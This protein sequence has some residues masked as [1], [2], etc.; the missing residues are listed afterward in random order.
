MQRF[1]RR[2]GFWKRMINSSITTMMIAVALFNPTASQPVN[3]AA[4]LTVTPITWNVVGLDS[5]NVS[6]GPNIFP[7]GA[8]VCNTGDSPATNVTATFAWLETTNQANIY[9]RAGTASTYTSSSSLNAGSCKDFF[10]EIEVLRAS[11]SYNKTRDYQ[12]SFTAD[13]GLTG[14]TPLPREIYVEKLV[15]QNR[16]SVT[17]IQLDGVSIPAG[18]VMT[19][20]V[21]N[22]YNITLF[23][24]TATAYNQLES[25]ISLSNTI[26]RINSVASTYSTVSYAPPSSD[27]LYADSCGWDNG[28][29]SPTYRSCIVSDGKSGGNVTV[30]YNVTILSGG[31]ANQMLNAMFYD[32]SGSSYH[33]N[34]DFSLSSRVVNVITPVEFSKIFPD[35]S[36]TAG[37]VTPLE[38]T[39]TNR[40]AT[41]IN[42]VTFND[43]LPTIGASQLT[44]A[45]PPNVSY[46]AG[47]LAGSTLTAV[48]GASSI[49]FSGGIAASSTCS[50][51]VDVQVPA[52]PTTGVYTNQS[53]TV[54]VNG[55]DTGVS[56]DA[57]LNVAATSSGTGICNLTL[58]EWKMTP[59]VTAENTDP[60]GTTSRASNVATAMTRTS[61]YVTPALPQLTTAINTTIG[62]PV[63]SW[64]ITTWSN[65]STTVNLTN[66]PFIEFTLDTRNYNTVHFNFDASISTSPSGP[67]IVELYSSTNGTS[68]SLVRRFTTLSGS[69]SNYADGTPTG[70]TTS[71]T[72]NTIFRLY[73]LDAQ[74]SGN[75]PNLYLDN[76]I[77]TGCGTPSPATISKSF[78]PAMIAA[79]QV[80][81]LTFT[82]SNPNG[83]NL[84]GAAF[85][86]SLPGD[87]TV[88][89]PANLSNTCGGTFNASGSQISL[90]GGT[91]PPAGCALSVNV[92]GSTAGIFTNTSGFLLTTE[93]GTNTSETGYGTSVLAVVQAPSFSK[94]FSPNPIYAGETS[95]L[96]F[97]IGNPNTVTLADIGLNDPLATDL[98]VASPAG[99][100]TTNCNYNADPGFSVTAASG[101]SNIQATAISIGPGSTC[102]IHVNVTSALE[103][104]YANSA[105]LTTNIT[106]LSVP[107]ATDTLAVIA[108]YPSLTLLKQ[109]SSSP[110]GPWSS[111]LNI[112]PASIV[113]YRL[114]V[115]NTGDVPLTNL[116]VNDPQINLSSC[117]WPSILPTASPTQ[118]PLAE[119]VIGPV[120][121]LSS[122]NLINT[123][124]ASADYSSST[125]TAESTAEYAIADL[126]LA[127]SIDQPAFSAANDVI[128]Y[129]YTLINNGAAA[130]A[131]P[132]NLY[133]SRTSVTCPPL[134]D[135]GNN[136]NFLD[137]AESIECHSN[138]TIT[139]ADI[140]TGSVINSAYAV[141]DGARSN[142]AR[143]T[144]YANQ[145]DLTISKTNNT[146]GY[147]TQGVD[148]TWTLRVNNLGPVAADF[149][150]D[151]QIL[152][153]TLPIGAAY[154]LNSISGTAGIGGTGTI[155]CQIAG[156][157]LTCA[158][159]GG[160]VTIAGTT[161]AFS[162]PITVTPAQG[163][164]LVNT[165]NVDGSGSISE[166]NEANNSAGNN[167]SIS[168][169]APS[170]S[171]V[172]TS[173]SAS[174][175]T[176]GEI[177]QY[178]YTITNTGTTTLSGPFSV[179][180]DQTSVT[181]PS[182]PVG[183]LPPLSTLVCTATY[184]IQ[185]SDLDSGSLTNVAQASGNGL[186]SDEETLT[187]YATQTP[188][189]TLEKSASPLTYTALNTPI[190]YSYHLTNSGNVTLS[191]PFSVSD[192]QTTVT[193]PATP[194]SLA[195][196]EFITCTASTTITQTDLDNGS[197]TNTATAGAFFGSNPV[198]STEDHATVNAV[199]SPAITIVKS[200][201]ESSYAAVDDVLHYTITAHNSGNVTLSGVAITDAALSSLT[202]NPTQP[203]TLAP[204]DDLICTGTYTIVQDDLDLGS[205]VNTAA[206]SATAPDTST[207]TEN[208]EVTVP[209]SN[210]P[211]ISLVKTITA[212]DFTDPVAPGDLISYQIL[213]TNTG[214]V[215]L[216]AVTVVD[217]LLASLDCTPGNNVS[218][219]PNA[220]ILCTASYQ[221]QQSD[222]D[223]GYIDNNA[224]V[225]S[226]LSDTITNGPSASDNIRQV[227]SAQPGLTLVKT[228][229][230]T[231]ISEAGQ[232]VSYSYE[233]TN[234]GTVT[235]YAPFTVTDDHL[236]V[237]CPAT[238]TL[239]VPTDSLTCS[240]DYSV[241][242]ADLDA[243][244][245][246]NVAAAGAYLQDNSP[247][248][249]PSAELTLPAEINAALGISK[250]LSSAP[251]AVENMPGVWELEFQFHIQNYGNQTLSA[252]QVTDDLAAA[253]ADNPPAAVPT[254]FTVTALSSPTLT[255]NWP[256]FTGTGDTNLLD[257]SDEL[258][259]GETAV[260]TLTLQITPATAATFENT[261]TITATTPDNHPVEDVSQDGA[262]PD[263]D[264]DGNPGNNN[265]ATPISFNA[266]NFAPPAG[267]KTVNSDDYPLLHWT[268][269][270]I[271]NQNA[272]PVS[273]RSL[274]PVPAGSSFVRSGSLSGYPLPADAPAGSTT[275]GVRC[276]DSSTVTSTTYCYFEAPT[277]VYPRGRIIWQGI[278]GAD[279]AG[280]TAANAAH[281]ISIQYTL[282]A[283][284]TTTQI[285]NVARLSVD[286]NQDGDFADAGESAVA[287]ASENWQK[288]GAPDTT[289]ALPESGFAPGKASPLPVQTADQTY[290]QFDNITLEI[291]ALKI[292]APIVGIPFQDG[293]WDITW[294]ENNAGWL[295][296]SAFPTWS[297]NSVLT[298][299]VWNADNSAG[300]FNQI[301]D[302]KYGD[303]V[304]IHAYGQT[305]VYEIRSNQLIGP[306]N[307]QAVM[308]H[309]Q[310]AWLTL[311]TCESYS[312]END[313]YR[314]RRML[315]A[316]LVSVE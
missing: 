259:P 31:G 295:N 16:N 200:A 53:E 149:P 52:S 208:D 75:G 223:R 22:T 94:Q 81:T 247:V 288:P 170:I 3:A 133:D 37:S 50:I 74:N 70:M 201:A 207:L 212:P 32:F 107:P 310:K 103:S 300:I 311:I 179:A 274:D 206:V 143:A 125:Y 265:A 173:L 286:A 51:W 267:E 312:P 264:H 184:S 301:K 198:S 131:G 235:L 308:Q 187:I 84:T 145:P 40:S 226:T 248:S 194:V 211:A 10:F 183:G 144:I 146:S 136:D 234:S 102:T 48:S 155:F 197:L 228:A 277:G 215:T 253:F 281:T 134:T 224:S 161:G 242:Q 69:I 87:L 166:S 245:V 76:M 209:S 33:Y 257:G 258:A 256:G 147:G 152:S 292:N 204:G 238:P 141:I 210:G 298:G 156:Q 219:A 19:M 185:Q 96:T 168:S 63:N 34:A 157:V 199:Q 85:T 182:V 162:M 115:E 289:Q 130:L 290:A 190:D 148:F 196:G 164:I 222:L 73:G 7:V 225:I 244:G 227:I 220:T 58:A 270:W 77:F 285:T 167:V 180:D 150:Q 174:Y 291:P 39:L 284:G 231:S 112:G 305:Y 252:V 4:E 262:S 240:G 67:R 307:V 83:T 261:A 13:G 100:T 293:E 268:A 309:E 275:Q 90:S 127:K 26:F 62:N 65:T 64:T 178:R 316:V 165:A 243:G 138:Y 193:C 17:N 169:S 175:D 120:T 315:K 30:N 20:T 57:N 151:S 93:G 249:S 113:Y 139:N 266:D 218:L 314:Y 92:T 195:S 95:T 303:Q 66:D 43:P 282:Q 186:T 54:W 214:G 171:M 263:P 129:T 109:V 27:L 123:A 6:V 232:V 306:K 176:L 99:V 89:T 35:V 229:N 2:S 116:S 239:L 68:F 88:A 192:D 273:A 287:S 172:K 296:G 42:N 237:T 217:D 251:Q 45:N 279:A 41:A 23:G 122:G 177:I 59:G 18:G 128:T 106:G 49:S 119:C 9:S 188:Q 233:L 79:G 299:H 24:T 137:P 278:L 8:R 114:T 47:C 80:S 61:N 108:H 29:T 121:S 111:F 294:L 12:I 158:A 202:C 86:D 97:T 105:S 140:L 191:A 153:D 117:V 28:P 203:A 205:V 36:V 246:T 250:E 11:S 98:V 126:I 142:T 38:F 313:S 46:S 269:V 159:Q 260:I 14:A 78:S 1:L 56:A 181:C 124:T 189:L 213:V 236:S 272:V 255:V 44:V 91:I 154:S 283:D 221:V 71:T 110:S 280:T 254:T 304:I 297:G 302:L 25:F 276:T 271:N 118:E 160:N 5:N 104:D 82:L 230:R 55:V 21:G 216:T 60:P 101:S 163:G 72:G 15:S 241:T 135:I 132:L